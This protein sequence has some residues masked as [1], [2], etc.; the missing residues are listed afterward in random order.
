[1]LPDAVAARIDLS[2]FAAPPVF[3][4]LAKA[5]RLDDAEMLKTFNCGI[6]MVVIAA[7]REVD[8]VLASLRAA[9]ET[10]TVIGEITAPGG[11][12][13]DAKGKGGAWAVSYM[14]ALRY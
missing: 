6:G 9:G 7:K 8:G 4:W 14:N 3:G 5:G 10:P 13:S 2:T 12:R 1:M 11:A